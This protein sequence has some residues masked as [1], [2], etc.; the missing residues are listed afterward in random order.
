MTMDRTK[1]PPGVE[2][3]KNGLERRYGRFFDD[4]SAAWADY[5]AI[6]LPARVA[7]LRDLA[8]EMRAN[9]A[10]CNDNTMRRAVAVQATI[11][12]GIAESWN[13]IAA[14]YDKRADALEK[15]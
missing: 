11:G 4:L 13:T 14:D 3:T 1:P 10:E 2:W 6:T 8:S 15:P 12:H 5:D 9:A 7:L